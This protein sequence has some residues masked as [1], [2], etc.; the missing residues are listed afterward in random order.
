MFVFRLLSRRN[1]NR[2]CERVWF[3]GS[4]PGIIVFSLSLSLCK[5]ASFRLRPLILILSRS[6]NNTYL[7]STERLLLSLYSNK[8]KITI[9]HMCVCE[10]YFKVSRSYINEISRRSLQ[11]HALSLRRAMLLPI[12]VNLC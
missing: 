11:R 5:C 1:D 7:C 9:Y 6:V 3:G 4:C 12:S 8:K 2:E 10:L